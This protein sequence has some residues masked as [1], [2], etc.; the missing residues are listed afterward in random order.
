MKLIAGY[1]RM[2]AEQF[3]KR[4]AAVFLPREGFGLIMQS[5][6]DYLAQR[7]AETAVFPL[8]D[9]LARPQYR[10]NLND[11]AQDAELSCDRRLLALAE[12]EANHLLL[13]EGLSATGDLYELA[14][15]YRNRQGIPPPPFRLP[16]IVKLYHSA[17]RGI[18][19]TDEEKRLLRQL[20]RNAK[21]WLSLLAL[22]YSY[23]YLELLS[24]R[25][26]FLYLSGD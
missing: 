5:E 3:F 20:A 6:V 15:P 18:F 4:S 22:I 8:T 11:L 23:D 16:L 21:T 10:G 19:R 25:L 13:T 1:D 9:S 12:L 17:A 24:S 7:F 2:F 14:A 26:S